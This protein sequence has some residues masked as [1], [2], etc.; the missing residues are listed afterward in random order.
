MPPNTVPYEIITD[1]TRIQFE[2]VHSWLANTYWAER[3]PADILERAIA[4]SLCFSAFEPEGK[5][6]V[7][8]A[9]VV[10]DYA[11][12]AYLCDVIVA[13]DWQGKGVGKAMMQAICD[14]LT[15]LGMR[16]WSLVTKDAHSL[17]EQ[18]GFVTDIGGK[19]MDVLLR[20]GYVE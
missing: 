6:Q 14:Y 9:R 3:I 18:F 13:E 7:G 1:K 8:F 17:Y 16:R 19:H 4:G 20:K 2:R 10:T 15:P 5:T 12:Y 11:T